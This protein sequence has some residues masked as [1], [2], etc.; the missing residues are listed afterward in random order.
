LDSHLIYINLDG[1]GKYYYDTF[2]GGSNALPNIHTLKS[3]GTWFENART[4]I[5]SITAPMQCAIVSGC[6]SDRTRNC[7]CYL[8]R[9]TKEMIA[10]RR[11]NVAQTFGQVLRRENR[12]C[13]SIQ[14]FAEENKGCFRNNE[15]NLY[16]QPAG[17]YEKRFA[18]LHDLIVSKS[19][20]YEDRIYRYDTFPD[21]VMLYIDDLDTLGH[22]PGKAETEAGRVSRVQGRLREIDGAIGT[23]VSDLMREGLWENMWLLVTSDHGMVHYKGESKVNSLQSFFQEAGYG[24]VA[25]YQRAPFTELPDVLL[26]S[27]GIECQVYFDSPLGLQ[28]SRALKER[29]LKQGYVDQVLTQDE[30]RQAGCDPR[31]ADMLISPVEGTHFG[32]E[33]QAAGGLYASHDSLHEKCNHVFG[34]LKGPGVK[35]GYIETQ[36]V[37]VTDFFPTLCRLMRLPIMKDAT[38]KILETILS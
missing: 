16:V 35:T 32:I 10:L 33:R 3:E 36:R 14:Q 24:P 8:N 7:Y 26:V 25:L 17:N 30:L 28:E 9:D 27:T 13:V 22:N 2:P 12:S 38:G 19:F 21:A 31:F 15:R 1:F 4:G 20:S 34:F 5:P 18:L 6:Y 29:L 23:M 37:N 11:Y